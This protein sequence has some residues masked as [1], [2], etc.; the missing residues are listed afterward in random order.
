MS[1]Y[2]RIKASAVEQTDKLTTCPK[3][4][5]PATGKFCSECAQPLSIIS[6]KMLPG[7]ELIKNDEFRAPRNCK[8]YYVCYVQDYMHNDIPGLRQ[9][10]IPHKRLHD[11]VT[12]IESQG[13]TDYEVIFSH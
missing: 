7:I 11:M 6:V 10:V 2:I 8:G 4:K 13:I 3:C 12:I 5:I 9:D 1:L